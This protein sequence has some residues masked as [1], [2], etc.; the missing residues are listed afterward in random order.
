MA[1]SARGII[2]F[3]AQSDFLDRFVL[4]PLAH[5]A[6]NWEATWGGVDVGYLPEENSFA[7]DLNAVIHLIADHPR[8]ARYHDH[9][10]RLA[11]LVL[12]ELKWPI[13]KK[14]GR[15]I[16]HDYEMILENGALHAF[17]S[18]ELIA[19]ACGRVHAALDFGQDHFD[20][21]EERHQQILAAILTIII[22]CRDCHG[23]SIL[24]A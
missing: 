11:E 13:Q 1:Y 16:G 18:R 5:I 12:N 7:A 17:S 23:E 4:R 19:A 21:M 20:V 2:A 10:D 6:G 8:P 3:F 22:Y 15:W 24:R 9:E 14:A